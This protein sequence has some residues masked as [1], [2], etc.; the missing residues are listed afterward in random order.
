MTELYP[1]LLVKHPPYGQFPDYKSAT[2][3]MRS[4]SQ[5][6]HEAYVRAVWPHAY[7]Y[8]HGY[9]YSVLS[10]GW[11]D[12]KWVQENHPELGVPNS[13]CMTISWKTYNSRW[14]SELKKVV[15]IDP[16]EQDRREKYMWKLAVATMMERS[17]TKEERPG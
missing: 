12:F 4:A 13:L 10:M 17:R 5:P 6:E 2:E 7:L 8:E 11:R 1:Y 15:P 9:D 16:I 3:W 14:D